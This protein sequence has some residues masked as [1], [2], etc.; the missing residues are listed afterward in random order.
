MISNESFDGYYLTESGAALQSKWLRNTNG[1]WTYYDSDG[2]CVITG[3]KKIGNYKYYFSNGS[4]VL[5]NTMIDGIL[6][7]FNSDGAYLEK[8]EIVSNGWKFIDGSYYYYD[9]G[10]KI[11]S[12]L[13]VIN[14]RKYAFDSYGRMIIEDVYTDASTGDL[15]YF[16]K[17]GEVASEG[18][19]QNNTIYVG[20]DGKVVK[21]L[22]TIDGKQYYFSCD[23]YDFAQN[24][25]G[26]NIYAKT[27]DCI[28]S[29][30]KQ[31]YVIDRTTHEV[32]Q[33][34]N[35]SGTR[36]YETANG[37]WFYAKEG[38]L[39]KSNYYIINGVRYAFD[40][41]GVMCE[42]NNFLSMNAYVE[43]YANS[44]GAIISNGWC[45]DV[46]YINGRPVI[47]DQV[48][49]GNYYYFDNHKNSKG[50]YF[51]D[52]NYYR[53]DAQGNRSVVSLKN[54]WTKVDGDWYYV[55]KGVLQTS[56]VKCING[57]NY[58]FNGYGRLVTNSWDYNYDNGYRGDYRIYRDENGELTKGWKVIGGKT[59]YFDKNGRT[60]S[61]KQT[62]DGMTYYFDLTGAMI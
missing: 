35:V 61:G 33:I 53:Y 55:E 31:I 47:L 52:G 10:E 18:W 9:N 29:D 12:Q 4:A 40:V 32:K 22:Q 23:G 38:R 24:G 8:S 15:Y 11:C 45:D 62:I 7:Y 2:R 54:G 36:W 46:Y 44:S 19:K 30:G 59:Y 14:G 34:V 25:H 43:G 13:R 3:W 21:G 50:I 6:Y 37:K 41:D 16:N 27:S 26:W 57:K 39:V 1:G 5:N 48:I 28:S 20:Y 60:V 56:C 58:R 42:N 49:D 17:D 51:V